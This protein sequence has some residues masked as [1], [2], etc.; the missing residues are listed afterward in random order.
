MQ[1]SEV[2]QFFLEALHEV[3]ESIAKERR[4]QKADTI[5]ANTLARQQGIMVLSGAE[6]TVH[7]LQE[8]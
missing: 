1:R 7:S 4:Q 5:R 3:R 6:K 2:E 8:R